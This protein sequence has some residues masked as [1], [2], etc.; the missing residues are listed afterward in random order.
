MNLGGWSVSSADERGEFHVVPVND[1][2]EHFD[3]GCKCCPVRDAVCENLWMHNS[4]DKR[5]LYETGELKL[6]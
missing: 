4:F 3:E 1:L 5:E 2:E 6:S